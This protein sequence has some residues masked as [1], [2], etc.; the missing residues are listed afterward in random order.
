MVKRVQARAVARRNATDEREY[1]A[2]SAIALWALA[3][4]YLMTTFSVF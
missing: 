3:A 2:W 1:V 4:A